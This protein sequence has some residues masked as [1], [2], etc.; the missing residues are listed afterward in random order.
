MELRLRVIINRIV[1]QN[2][3][4]MFKSFEAY[5]DDKI[6]IYVESTL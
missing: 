2:L 6:W 3:C 1:V 5:F 4:L